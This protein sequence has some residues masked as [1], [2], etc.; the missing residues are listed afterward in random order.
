[1]SLKG[2]N[3]KV[4]KPTWR[5]SLGQFNT[6]PSTEGHK[7]EAV[8]GNKSHGSLFVG[9]ICGWNLVLLS[10]FWRWYHAHTVNYCPH[11][12]QIEFTFMNVVSKEHIWR[13]S[14]ASKKYKNDNRQ[15]ENQGWIFF[16]VVFFFLFCLWKHK[17]VG[18][19][20]EVV[21]VKDK[22]RPWQ[23]RRCLPILQWWRLNY[24]KWLLIFGMC[25]WT[26]LKNHFTNQIK[27]NQ[28]KCFCCHCV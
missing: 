25:C 16:S 23:T 21:C 18:L 8:R 22:E 3:P 28:M 13:D 9:D 17:R 15:K 12:L 24:F 5:C 19:W 7:S 27:P 14:G 1:M 4:D 20:N 10:S 26:S 6:S 2:I 11:C